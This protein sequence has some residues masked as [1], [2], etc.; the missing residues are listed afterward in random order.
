M[1]KELYIKNI[2][3]I[4]EVRINF[5]DGFNVLTGET[6]AGK[7]ILIDSINMA[8][9]ARTSKD[10]VR[11]G[12]D[13]AV[14][15][16]CFSAGEKINA[17]LEENGIETDEESVILSR[18]LTKDAKSTS[19][20]NGMTVT[21]SIL[22]EA[23]RLL[24]DIHG[25]NDN[26]FLLSNKYHISYLDDYAGLKKE[27]EAYLEKYQKLREVNKKIKYLLQNDEDKEKRA[28][29]LSFQINEIDSAKL[30]KGESEELSQRISYL[31]NI[32]KI[33]S[34]AAKAHEALYEGERSAYDFVKDA[35]RALN[36][37][38]SYEKGLLDA[39]ARLESAALEIE[40]ISSYLSSYLQD[41]EFDEKE[42]DALNFR[43]DTINELKRKYKASEE[44][45]LKYR[46][47][48]AEELSEL[49]LSGETLK[50]LQNEALLL[51][52][53]TLNSAENLH[54][55]REK[56]AERLAKEVM[57]ELSDLDMPK[58]V[59]NVGIT[60]K[61]L[62]ETGFDEA[63]FKLSANPGEEPRPL[64]K[65]ASGGEL[66]RI[67]L[68]LKS[69]FSD[70]DTA[71]TLIFDEIDTGVSGRAAQKIAEKL[72]RLSR[73]KQVFSI[74][75]LAQI[76]S[77]ADCHYLIKKTL[78]NDRTATN[79]TLL[80]EEGRTAELARIIGGAYITDLTLKNA[81]EMLTL[82]KEVKE[83]MNF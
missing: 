8:I 25:Q 80:G 57:S 29:L 44:E 19:R 36:A 73:K 82:A 6:G 59:F 61:E 65:I 39:A 27:K 43:L 67:M 1:L 37:A 3:V 50:K 26:Y 68:A 66:S 12:C 54:Q 9:G 4:E 22:K 34:A 48:I 16:A 38:G 2:A 46:D 21:G 42:F 30:K 24:I 72:S 32:E 60:K 10:L 28:E 40:D 13:K 15:S 14:V 47:K 79:V 83:K 62:S 70:T 35:E 77:M 55:K 52:K 31:A 5:E 69:I 63:E 58:V 64:S 41:A 17:F 75:H 76:A 78:N 53:E 18:Q 71:E 7:S 11:T 81:E 33:A 20:I 74:T 23:G 45:I 51:E 56:A 49:S